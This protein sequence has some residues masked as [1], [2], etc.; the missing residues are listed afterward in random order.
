MRRGI[1]YGALLALIFACGGAFAAEE[2]VEALWPVVFQRDDNIC[3]GDTLGW[4][5]KTVAKGNDAEISPDGASVA[6]TAS[7][8]KGDGRYI[9]VLDLATK[10]VTRLASVP[11]HNS[12]GP[13]WSPDG[14][15][16]L[17]NHWD[18]TQGDW[19]FAVV[20][21]DG[22][23]FRVLAPK[24]YGIY[25]PFWSS[26][27]AS[28]YGHNLDTLYRIAADTGKVMECKRLTDI[29][30][31]EAEPSSDIRFSVSPDGTQWLF[32]ATVR[33]RTTWLMT[34]DDSFG[35][36][37]LYC[38]GDGTVK[39]LTDDTISACHASWLQERGEY[40]FDGIMEE[41]GRKAATP[42]MQIPSIIK[43][44]VD[45]DGQRVLFENGYD[46]SAAVR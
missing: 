3:L 44:S 33:N 46:P 36:L 22:K 37:F 26:D 15:T 9:A 12:Y 41:Q 10:R 14:E 17:F 6:F 42:E 32:A 43:R 35:A 5:S 21:K 28:V 30:G 25:S 27:G 31:S 1:L 45:H 16:L 2:G 34:E 19:R 20:S 13:R 23:D 11:G 39:R 4:E 38:P 24:L 7:D 40:L 29:L 18:S 8:D